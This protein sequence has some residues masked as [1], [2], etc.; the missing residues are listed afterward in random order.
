MSKRYYEGRTVSDM[1]LDFVQSYLKDSGWLRTADR[2]EA[3]DANDRPLPWM[4]YPAI[5]LLARVARPA[6]SV[7]EFGSGGS[8]LWWRDRVGRVVSV[9]HDE[10]WAKETGA[11]SRPAGAPCHDKSLERYLGYVEERVDTR[12]TNDGPSDRDYSAYL[13]ALLEHPAG[14][15]D[16][17]VIDGVARNTGAA[18]AVDVVKPNGLVVFDNSDRDDYLVGYEV[19]RAAGFARL[20]FWGPGPI[21]PY[22]WCTSIFARS[23]DLFR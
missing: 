8:T 10:A 20:D 6:M 12:P 22:G 5:T 7:F 18:I 3:I 23:L 13:A 19:L 9:E 4:T 2:K 1:I 17:I 16:V 14:T 11:L 15:F 21:N